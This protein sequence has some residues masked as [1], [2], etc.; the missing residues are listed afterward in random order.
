MFNEI[1]KYI[2]SN[3]CLYPGGM[4]DAYIF[5]YN[6]CGRDNYRLTDYFKVFCFHNTREFI[7]M[8]PSIVNEKVFP[9]IDLNYLRNE[10]DESNYTK[11]SQ[12][13]KFLKK[14]RKLSLNHNYKE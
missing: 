14:Y 9:C 6:E 4:E 7:T 3:N 12:V 8:T 13:D 10:L 11:A 2:P 5:K 1:K